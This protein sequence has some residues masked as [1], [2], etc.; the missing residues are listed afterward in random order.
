[1]TTETPSSQ[2]PQGVTI[3][4]SV[5]RWLVPGLLGLALG[6]GTATGLVGF[7]DRG[8]LQA[9]AEDLD[10]VAGELRDLKEEMIA[11]RWRR[12]DHQ[13]WVRDDLR[14]DLDEIRGRLD[15]LERSP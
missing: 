10:E 13:V 5:L 9:V 6:G 14:P 4:P 15:A 2:A 3:P 12:S 8:E 1:M 7:A 11:D